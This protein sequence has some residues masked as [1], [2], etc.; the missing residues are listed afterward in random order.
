MDYEGKNLLMQQRLQDDEEDNDF[1]LRWI[2]GLDLG[3][4]SRSKRPRVH[5]GSRPRKA[6][7]VE[8]DREHMHNRM[9]HNYFSKNPM[10]GPELFRR[11]YRLRQESF[12]SNLENIYFVQKFDACGLVGL[13]SHHKI[14][15]ALWLLCYGMFADATDE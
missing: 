12:F 8:R 13:S 1:A 14:T 10:F 7:N 2:V 3:S 4:S 15:F 9:M 6:Q 11:R 5:R